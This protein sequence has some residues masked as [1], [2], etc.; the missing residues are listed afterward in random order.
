MVRIRF[1]FDRVV[2]AGA[3]QALAGAS[4]QVAKRQ[5]NWVSQAA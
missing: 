3:G 1:S 2:S 5:W 4:H